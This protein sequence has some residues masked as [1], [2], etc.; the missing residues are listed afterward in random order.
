MG[1]F[2]QYRHRGG[3]TTGFTTVPPASG[4]WVYTNAAGHANINPTNPSLPGVV[5]AI[6]I[7][8]AQATPNTIAE[9]FVCPFGTGTSGTGVYTGGGNICAR[10]AYRTTGGVLVS[11]YSAEK[12][13][14]F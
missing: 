2:A 7:I 11:P 12:I 5:D 1:H 4:S 10:I 9:S 6:A 3:G 13:V 8:Y 14:A